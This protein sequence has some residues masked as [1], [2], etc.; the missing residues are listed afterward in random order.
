[1]DNYTTERNKGA[2]A[3]LVSLLITIRTTGKRPGRDA[4]SITP[5]KP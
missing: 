4:A 2:K 5:Y 1:M 3:I